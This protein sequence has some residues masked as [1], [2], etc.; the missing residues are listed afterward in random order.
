M[1]GP[2]LDRWIEAIIEERAVV[3]A[4]RLAGNDTHLTR[5]H[6]AGPYLPKS[7]LFG[8]LPELNRP[9]SENPRVTLPVRIESHGEERQV[10]AIWYNG[11]L[12]GRTRNETRLTGFGGAQSPLLD[13][14]STGA[15]ALFAFIRTPDGPS[16]SIWLCATLEEEERLE[17][18]VGAVDPGRGVIWEPW[19]GSIDHGLAATTC[20]LPRS[21]IPEEWVQD[22][23]SGAEVIAKTLE[24]L[25]GT[26][27]GPDQRLLRRRDCEFEVFQSVEE[28]ITLP[29]IRQGFGTMDAFLKQAQTLLQRRK[30][31]SGRSLELQVRAILK[32]EGL[33]EGCDF[34]YNVESDPGKRP[35]FLFPSQAA[36]RNGDFPPDRLVMLATKTTCRDRWRQV[37]NEA[38]RIPIKHLLTLQEGVTRR[39]HKEMTASGV[40]LVVPGSIRRRYTSDLRPFIL[41]LAEFL[42]IVRTQRT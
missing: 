19:S 2:R 14:E 29:R 26:A 15:L 23:P 21:Q 40:K 1:I 32:E 13:P 9:G 42:D 28:A 4:K 6:Q 34:E 35:D 31:R 17:A 3:F 18:Y 5:A 16:C 8:A 27:L 24:L 39:Q 20:Q 25:H 11:K 12:Y 41:T 38:D 30:S 36:Y 37:L 7:F 10:N 33:V 22:F